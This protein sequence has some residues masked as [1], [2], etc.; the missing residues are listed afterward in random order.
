MTL[1]I[2]PIIIAAGIAALGSAVTA[3]LANRR[4]KKDREYQE[5]LYQKQKQD[6]EDAA[7][8]QNVYNAPSA[9]KARMKAAGLSPTMMYGGGAGALSDAAIVRLPQHGFTPLAD[10]SGAINS[11][12]STLSSALMDPTKSDAGFKAAVKNLEANARKAD[13]DADIRQ[14]QADEEAFQ[15][16]IAKQM[17][18]YGQDK[19]LN[20]QIKQLELGALSRMNEINQATT[21][22][23]IHRIHSEAAKAYEDAM[24]AAWNNEQ[25]ATRK[26][27]L[28]QQLSQAQTL[29]E[30]MKSQQSQ[31]YIKATLAQYNIFPTD[32]WYLRA[33][34]LLAGK[35]KALQTSPEK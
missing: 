23:E 13:A 9:V 27:I 30:I 22:D 15:A 14:I 4:A 6:A 3:G 34:A 31:E 12:T 29:S 1:L 11:F 19:A 20:T 10:Y 33:A 25:N 2:A 24:Q 28:A 7:R 5:E 35:I 26:E 21:Q 18:I 17:G 8:Q 16:D 32:E